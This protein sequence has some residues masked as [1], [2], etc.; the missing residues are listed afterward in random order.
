MVSYLIP[1]HTGRRAAVI[2]PR[3]GFVL[4]LVSLAA[5]CATS[6]VTNA[7]LQHFAPDSGY[8]F[9]NTV[10]DENNS[11]S[12][13]VILTFSGGGTRAASMAYGVLEQLRD[14]PIQ[15]EGQTRR[16]LDEVDLISSVSGGSLPAAYYT[17]FGDRFFEDFRER[18]LYED[19]QGSL[20]RRVLLPPGNLKLFSTFYSRTDILAESFDRNIF[21]GKTYGDLTLQ[22]N[23]P[24]LMVNSTNMGTGS[25]FEFTQRQFDQLYSDLSSYHIGYAVA[26]SACFP[27]AFPSMTVRNYERGPDHAL[28]AWARAALESG[29]PG[30]FTYQHAKDLERYSEEDRLYTHLSD[31]GIAD[32]LGLLPVIQLLKRSDEGYT[33]PAAAVVQ[34]AKKI[35]ILTVNAEVKPPRTWDLVQSPISLIGTLL[36][37]SSLPM[38][39]FT[40]AQIDYLKLMIENQQ[41]RRSLAESEGSGADS[42]FPELHF[43]VVSVDAEVDPEKRAALNTIPT[44]FKLPMEDVDNLRATSSTI[45]RTNPAF[46][47]FLAGLE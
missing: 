20:L 4:L 17:L 32:N 27:G 42:T 14:T 10:P 44:S 45:L 5:G 35:L 22:G 24:F 34:R 18:V 47:A 43:V 46:Q 26:A 16:L 7:R 37:A 3:T 23:R 39:N 11:E 1:T 6:P 29:T 12:L 19:I 2:G 15:W 30:T 38:S 40:A 33:S 21:E 9:E 25:R 31:G 28:P 13:F 36:A 8:R 41:L